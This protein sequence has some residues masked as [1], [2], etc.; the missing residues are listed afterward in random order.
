[1]NNRLKRIAFITSA[2]FLCS[3]MGPYLSAIY[4]GQEPA[5]T[6]PVTKKAVHAEIVAAEQT[7]PVIERLTY[8]CEENNQKEINSVCDTIVA[9]MDAA[10]REVAAYGIDIDEWASDEI[11]A[12]QEKYEN[13][14]NIKYAET[15]KA[16]EEL[17][18]GIDSE[19]NLGI[20]SDNIIESKEHHYSD[21]T[22]NIED[23]SKELG[24]V[25][26][27]HITKSADINSPAPSDSDLRYEGGSEFPE[28]IQLIADSFDDANSIYLYVKNNI[29]Y[30][31]YWGSKKEAL[32]TLAQQGGND[33]D[34]A[35]LLIALLRAKGIPARYVT[36]T[37]RITPQQA[38]EITGATDETAAGRIIAGGFRNAKRILD[39][40]T[41]IGYMMTRTWVEAYIPYTD[42][43]GAGNK[44]GE[45]VWVQ[46]DPSFKTLDSHVKNISADYNSDMLDIISNTQKYYEA[47]SEA[48]AP[49]FDKSA[50]IPCYFRSIVKTEGKYI[51]STL[52]YTLVG[53]DSRY[54]VMRDSDKDKISIGIDGET[55]VTKP[56]SQLY[57]KPVTISYE[58]AHSEDASVMDRYDNLTEVPAYLVNV[59]PVVTIGSDKYKITD[60]DISWLF[61]TQLGTDHQMFVR[62][63]TGGS[64]NIL[65]DNIMSGSMYSVNLDLQTITNDDIMA[66]E[67]RTQAAK[68]NFTPKNMCTPDE[69][70]AFLN[71]A[72][73]YYFSLCD[74]Q[75]EMYSAL[76]NIEKTR[77]LGVAITGYRFAKSASFGMVRNLDYGSFYID[78]AYNSA[79][80]VSLDGDK[81]KENEFILGL[82]TIESYFEGYLWE[83]LIDPE[84]TCISTV[85]VTSIAAK[86]GIAPVY[87]TQE[88]ADK[89]LENCNITKDVKEEVMDFVNRGLMV[90]LV[91]ETLT[92]G[93]WT[94]TAYTAIDMETGS[95]SYM[96]SG[97]TAGG[98]SMNF[99]NLF[100]INNR[101]V[102]MNI[103][104]CDLCM[105]QGYMTFVSGEMQR[106]GVKL[107]QG[108]NAMINSATALGMA[109]K[110]RYDNYDFIFKYAETDNIDA[111]MN[112]YLDFTL[113]NL[114]DTFATVISMYVNAAGQII[115]G[116]NELIP[117][118]LEKLLGEGIAK[119]I[120]DGLTNGSSTFITLYH[121]ITQGIS[122]GRNIKNLGD[123]YEGPDK[124]AWIVVVTDLIGNIVGRMEW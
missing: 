97:G 81:R 59:K 109:M 45:G 74:S 88:N 46:L 65:V 80:T 31:P 47:N 98:S 117:A 63:S 68:E 38:L 21:A 73:K 13:E 30:E 54:S 51:P 41:V 120:A 48:E 1:M 103:E 116:L 70:G 61:E 32:I 16:V 5:D 84:E 69:L 53:V 25:E 49:A 71:Y 9:E 89:K 42:Y 106:D 35:S 91:P 75:G 12:R 92:I 79:L 50:D 7:A 96:I 14:L 94:G 83:Q 4:K 18:N 8:A 44:S 17:R 24:S 108:A 101:L 86:Q 62:I 43:R 6:K 112:E 122:E 11:K 34:Q 100:N 105:A 55:I 2:V 28:P 23:V 37:S 113:K 57:G 20:I 76:S 115:G 15:S 82:G 90:E 33:L 67:S 124:W 10:K 114:L 29:K 3:A 99:E 66:C 119:E 102:A 36:G 95:A 52:P 27:D 85:S 121:A 111:V 118:K 104:L 58:P 110:M 39:N 56:V 26:D 78:V 40:G 72:G 93:D 22:P 60:S 64:T 19:K 107:V 77:R 87:I 123:E